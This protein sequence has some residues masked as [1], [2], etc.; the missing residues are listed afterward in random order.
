MTRNKNNVL[1]SHA[2]KFHG[3]SQHQL[4]YKDF[5]MDVVQGHKSNISRQIQEGQLISHQLKLRDQEMRLGLGQPRQIMNSK[6]E[7]H[8]PGLIIPRVSKILY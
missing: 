4:T 6:L 5:H 7:F 1:H 3:G 2:T 8:Q